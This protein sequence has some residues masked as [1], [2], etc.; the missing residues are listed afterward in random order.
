MNANK[1]LLALTSQNVANLSTPGYSR[2][3]MALTNAA[4][5]GLGVMTGNPEAIRNTIVAKSL[6]NTFGSKGFYDGQLD[7]LKLAEPA[8]ND[9]DGAGLSQSMSAFLDALGQVSASPS[10]KAERAQLVQ[11]ANGLSAQFKITAQGLDDAAQ[12]SINQVKD[13]VQ[14]IN[15]KTTD[16]AA[17]NA[18]IKGLVNTNQNANALIDQRDLLLAELSSLVQVQVINEPDGTVSIFAAGG[19]P[20]LEGYEAS[21]LKVSGPDAAGNFDVVVKKP[22]G[23]EVEPLGDFGGKLG[24][25][26]AAYKDDILPAIQKLDEMAFTFA[27]AFNAQ[28]QAGVGIDGSTGLDFFEPIAGQQGAAFNLNVSEAIK[29]NP[30][31][32]AAASDIADIPGGNDNLLLLM[33][34]QQDGGLLSD[35]AS[36]VG[37]WQDITHAI[38]N[39]IA[40]ATVGSVTEEGTA[41]QL[42]ALQQAESGVSLDEEMINMTTAQKSLEAASTLIRTADEMFDTVLNLVR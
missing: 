31:A 26:M 28:H 27:T 20:L 14:K 25:I 13:T 23:L 6:L 21:S 5:A 24:G 4:V 10:G 29:T 42:I 18:Q 2:Q 38:G 41:D 22:N 35:G 17:L 39:A 36:L 32:I 9:L 37:A 15:Q 12:G 30:D 19:R 7:S 40:T 8:V 33:K 16:I 11:A 34:V 3:R 1:A